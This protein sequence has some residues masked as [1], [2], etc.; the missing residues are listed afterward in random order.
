MKKAAAQIKSITSQELKTCYL[1]WGTEDLLIT[2]T[3]Q[4]FEQRMKADKE[5]ALNTY[6][7]NLKEASIE[8]IVHEAKSLPFFGEKKLIIV[9]D[10]YILTGKK[11][12]GSLSHNLEQLEDYLSDP[13]DFTVIVFVAPYDK[14]DKRKKITKHLLK[15]A[16]V[17]EAEASKQ[18]E[19]EAFLTEFFQSR[20]LRIERETLQHLLQLTDW[21]LT[22]AAGE[23]EKLALYHG[24]QADITVDAVDRLVSKSLEQNIFE[25]N[26]RVLNR[27]VRASI[28]LY[29]DLLTQK[30]D[31]IKILA[32]MISQ[33]RL[34]LQ[35]KILK[36]KGYQQSDIAAIL[37]V[38]PYR[39]KL[40]LQK[41]QKF[42]QSI[43]SEAH[44]MLI[45]A[46]YEVKT[47]RSNPE[48]AV[49]LFIMQF[50]G[51][52]PTPTNRHL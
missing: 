15:Q 50:A 51:L 29:Q 1:V 5:D 13:S 16:E 31:P 6:H 34:L 42:A 39:V 25:L 45:T 17:I 43:L 52:N 27:Q 37:K 2:Q 36:S 12:T 46:D 41:E 11:I 3:I 4:A 28:E 33:F 32:L 21:N 23:A 7:F 18:G 38:H 20:D 14:L 26:D 9:H 44:H 49:E 8:D 40:A 22:R 10:S 19:V 24:N 35:V 30:E 48:M 47:G